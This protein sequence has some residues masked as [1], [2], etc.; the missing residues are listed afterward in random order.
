MNLIQS[1]AEAMLEI[2]KSRFLAWVG[3]VQSRADVQ[4]CLAQIRKAHPDAAHHCWAWAIGNDAAA[5]DDGEPAGTAGKPIL[6][7]LQHKQLTDALA[8]VTRYYGGIKLGAGG[9]VRAYGQVVSM[10]VSSAVL[11]PIVATD[12]LRLVLPIEQENKVRNW[13]TKAGLP[14]TVLS[15]DGGRLFTITL[16]KADL[17]TTRAALTELT[18]GRAMWK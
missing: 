11:A 5:N 12:A 13:L 3:P 18:H 4:T 15:G 14:F 9:L 6:N 2:K 17:S 8:V 7:V 16:P 1:P 10:A